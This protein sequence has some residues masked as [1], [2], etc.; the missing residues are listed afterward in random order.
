MLVLPLVPL[1]LPLPPPLLVPPPPFPPMVSSGGWCLQLPY[2]PPMPAAGLLRG[3][4]STVA[5]LAK[6]A[7]GLLPGLA[8]RIRVKGG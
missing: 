4:V 1:L 8:H 2:L 7:A 6:P 5:L 3:L